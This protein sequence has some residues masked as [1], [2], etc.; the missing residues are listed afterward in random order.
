MA[1]DSTPYRPRARGRPGAPLAVAFGLA[2]ALVVGCV[3][4]P[5]GS[6][7]A[8]ALPPRGDLRVVVISDLNSSYGSTEYEPEVHRAVE[9]IVSRLRPDLVLAAGDLIA[10]QRPT[11]T[12]ADVRAMWAAFDEAIGRPL[13]EAGI[14]FGF[15]LG[16]HD[17]SAYP[18]HERDRRLALEHWRAS[19]H[20]TG[21]AWVDGSGFPVRHSFLAGPLFVLSWDASNAHTID[22]AEAMAWVEAQLADPAA[23][24]ARWRIV[25]GHLPLYAVAVGR[26]RP[27]EVLDRPDELRRLLEQLE[28]DMYVSGHHHAFYPGRRGNLELLHAGALGQGAR[29]LIGHDAPP[30]QT[31]TL[32]DFD[33]ASGEIRWTT[34]AFD[35]D[36]ADPRILDERDLPERIEGHNGWVARRD[37]SGP[38]VED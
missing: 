35:R 6:E 38:F 8:P 26:D 18:A 22:D 1:N 23:R 33:V 31:M 3:S 5:A 16:N 13:R 32:L 2:A 4:A 9:M 10:G 24:A 12:D 15:T 30:V 34:F 27:G 25:L 28:V 14:P 17:G 36:D 21:V 19:E 20:D 37:Q 7:S 29:Q 11:L